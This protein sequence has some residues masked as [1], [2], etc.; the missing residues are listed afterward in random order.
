MQ[1]ILTDAGGNPLSGLS[2]TYTA[3]S[4]G[5]G[6]SFSGNN[7]VTTDAQGSAVAPPFTANAVMGSYSVVA[8]AGSL[9]ATF[10]LTNVSTTPV[11]GDFN[12]DGLPDVVWQDPVSGSSQTW[13]LNGS[14]AIGLVGTAGISTAN[15]WHIVAVADFNG[16]GNPDVVW[17]DPNSGAAQVWFLGPPGTAV[18]GAAVLTGSNPWRIVGAADFNRDGY[19]DLVWQDPVSGHVQIWYLGGPQGITLSRAANLTISNPWHVVGTGDFNGDGQP[20]LLWQDPV[21]GTV[22]IWYLGGPG[23]N[24]FSS[25]VN[26]CGPNTWRIESVADFNLDGHPDVVWQD[27]ASGSSQIWFLNGAQ[28]AGLMGASVLSGPN[29]W[30]VAG[31]R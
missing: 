9:N 25:A 13:L 15:E 7:T 18:L 22:Q 14:Q 31:P 17:Q 26:L 23:G 19:P 30:R 3:P 21:R 24:V 20:D 4:T 16:D 2:V 1:A 27:P 28:G 8:T 11:P 12:G 10:N 6:G 29:A 5:A